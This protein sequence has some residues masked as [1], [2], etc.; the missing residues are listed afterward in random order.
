[1]ISSVSIAG[2]KLTAVEVLE[3]G[4]QGIDMQCPECGDPVRVRKGKDGHI[5]PHFAHKAK[6][7]HKDCHLRRL[8]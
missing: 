8:T 5:D 2:K 6:G 1:M 3:Q 7:V 4:Y